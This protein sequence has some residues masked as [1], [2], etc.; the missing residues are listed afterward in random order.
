VLTL[1]FGEAKNCLAGFAFAIDVSFAVAEFV[2]AKLKKSTEFIV[3]TSASV[4][5]SRHHSEYYPEEQCKGY[6]PTDY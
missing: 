2:S 5:I 1:C 6:A 3:F 4:Y